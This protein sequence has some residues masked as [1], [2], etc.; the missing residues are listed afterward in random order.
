VLLE[1]PVNITNSKKHTV[2]VKLTN[3]LIPT[4]VKVAQ[5]PLIVVLLDFPSASQST[6]E[7]G[8]IRRSTVPISFWKYKLRVVSKIEFDNI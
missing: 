4:K 2:V 8:Q 1:H 3:D 5:L 6:V 7:M